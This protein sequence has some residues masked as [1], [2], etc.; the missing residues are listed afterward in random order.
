MC[1]LSGNF[2]L[3]R[4]FLSNPTYAQINED[5][6]ERLFEALRSNT[7]LEC[8]SLSNTQLGDKPGLLLAA[9]LEKNGSLK[10]LK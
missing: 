3:V 4:H 1:T 6:F 9:V 8:L 2:P 7:R 10:K 5:E